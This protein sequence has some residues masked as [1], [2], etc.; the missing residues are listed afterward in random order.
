MNKTSTGCKH[1][2][3]V[4]DTL[5]RSTTQSYRGGAEARKQGSN[6]KA[7]HRGGQE[8]KTKRKHH[9][10]G[11]GE[12]MHVWTQCHIHLGV[13]CAATQPLCVSSVCACE[14]KKG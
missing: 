3:S 1:D 6:T 8:T 12:G 2:V 14:R 5:R 9:S 13:G 7:C 4:P 10:R 11:A